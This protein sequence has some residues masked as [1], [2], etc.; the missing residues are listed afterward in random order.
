MRLPTLLAFLA[1]IQA[2]PVHAGWLRLPS[3]DKKPTGMELAYA[4]TTLHSASGMT[5]AASL[6][7]GDLK[8]SAKLGAGPSEA[9][10]RFAKQSCIQRLSLVSDG[11]EGRVVLLISTD[12]LVWTTLG[13]AQFGPANPLAS[14]DVGRAQGKYVK[15][16]FE[17]S[18]GGSVRGVQV[19]GSDSDANYIVMQNE[20]ERGALLNFATGI[21]GGR[22]IFLSDNAPGAAKDAQ[23]ANCFK[24]STSGDSRH[25]TAVYDLGEMRSLTEFGSLHSAH[26]TRLQ[27][28]A[29]ETLPEKENWRGRP[30][31]DASV[32]DT[33]KPVA[34]A[35]DETGRG[36]LTAK[37]AQK[38]KAR[39]VALRW[40]TDAG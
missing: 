14:V 27:V 34:A 32:F 35:E 10:L 11:A 12:N 38:V 26:P 33:A 39:F 25:H 1:V 23:V 2:I 15:L 29:F 37:A 24:F 20:R 18:K 28:Y 9:V 16:S 21:G 40:E 17:L 36:Y 4:G 5:D 8:K 31:F 6:I 7:M 19:M 22:L 3:L 30:A 13:E